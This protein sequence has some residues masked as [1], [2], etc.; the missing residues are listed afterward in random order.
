MYMKWRHYDMVMTGEG[1]LQNVFSKIE[2]LM[3]QEIDAMQHLCT[4]QLWIEYVKMVDIMKKFIKSEC[5]GNWNLHLK[6]CKKICCLTWQLLVTTFTPN[7]FMCICQKFLSYQPAILR[8]KS[9]LRV[10]F[11]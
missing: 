11:M 8:Y 6:L 9:I 4:T 2:I 5:T 1:E 7:Q 10:A 3:K